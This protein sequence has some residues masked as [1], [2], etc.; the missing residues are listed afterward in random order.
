MVI[1]SMLVAPAL[2]AA[3][4]LVGRRL[5]P[6]AAGWVAALPVSIAAAAVAVALDAGGAT[7]RALALS[8]AEHV[9]AQVAFAAVLGVVLARRGLVR[10]LAAGVAA[11]VGGSVVLAHVPAAVAVAS[12]VSLLAVAQRFMPA[13][14]P[15]TASPRR[16]W[17]TAAAF[18]ATAIVVA[19]TLQATRLAGP[20]I[21]GAV[22]AF[23]TLST[24]LAVSIVLRD[25][26]AA[27]TDA[28]LGLVRGLPCYLTFCLVLAVCVGPLGVGAVALALAAALLAGG[29]TWRRVPLAA[30]AR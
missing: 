9:P 11:Y 28:L 21:G 13:R 29:L 6:S 27:G 5:G 15:E 8:A 1:V 19:A 12:A 4:S 7:A 10:A 3:A 30:A 17:A 24:T 26:R 18:A 16:W 22:A 14:R 23:P 25:G 2:M 20:G